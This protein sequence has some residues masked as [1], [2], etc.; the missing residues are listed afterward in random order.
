MKEIFIS[1]NR[2][3]YFG[4]ANGELRKISVQLQAKPNV[5]LAK[6]NQCNKPLSRL[7]H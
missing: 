3:G 2:T 5:F 1:K 6:D 7:L 4:S